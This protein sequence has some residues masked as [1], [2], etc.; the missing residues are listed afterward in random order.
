MAEL[1]SSYK[2]ELVLSIFVCVVSMLRLATSL[3]ESLYYFVVSYFKAIDFINLFVF[4]LN[5]VN[6]VIEVVRT[7]YSYQIKQ[8]LISLRLDFRLLVHLHFWL[9][10]IK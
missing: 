7:W 1:G 10:C 6:M 2:S 8:N 3:F 5:L 9:Y 4:G